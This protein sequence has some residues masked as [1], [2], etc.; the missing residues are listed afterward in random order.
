MVIQEYVLHLVN[1]D[2]IVAGEPY[3]LEGPETIVERF[4]ASRTKPDMMLRVGDPVNGM[5]YI[6]WNNVVYIET[7]N[8]VETNSQTDMVWRI[9]GINQ[10][11]NDEDKEQK[12]SG[13]KTDVREK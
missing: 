13:D 5:S 4:I 3:E 9:Y 7:G 11:K 8:V 10:V 1:G 2:N 12:Q 6:P